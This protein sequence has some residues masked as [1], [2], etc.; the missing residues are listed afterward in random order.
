MSQRSKAKAALKREHEKR[1]KQMEEAAL[2]RKWEK[3]TSQTGGFSRS[4]STRVSQPKKIE[5]PRYQRESDLQ[6]ISKSRSDRYNDYRTPEPKAKQRLS[7]EMQKREEAALARYQELK[8]RTGPLGNKMGN[9]F[10]GELDLAEMR[11]GGLR[12]RS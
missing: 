4:A 11:A 5:P 6:L 9:Q 1:Q 7:E 12:R 10:M 2:Q 8:A 3:L